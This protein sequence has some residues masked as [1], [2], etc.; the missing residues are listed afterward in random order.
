MIAFYSFVLVVSALALFYSSSKIVDILMKLEKKF[1]LREFIIGFFVMA[2]VSSLPNLFLAVTSALEKIPQLSFGDVIGGNVVD[3]T[4][5]AALAVLFNPSSIKTESRLAQKSAILCSLIAILPLFLVF[6]Q[7]LSRTDGIILIISFFIYALWTFSKRERFCKEY[8]ITKKERS[9]FAKF[10]IFVAIL[11]IIGLLFVLFLATQG[12][13]SSVREFSKAFNVSIPVIGLLIVGLG[14]CL[15]EMYLCVASARRKQGFMVLGDLMG[16][17]II[18]AT[19]V[20]GIAAVIHPIVITDFSPFVVARIFL[21]ISAF[22]FYFAVKS[23]R[24]ITKKEGLLLL[25][26]YVLFLISEAIILKS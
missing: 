5:V 26:L 6:D 12:I 20:L 13:I 2:F 15:P 8:R 17:V 10:N 24:E 19:L 22:F 9:F 1:G 11:K 3:L 21:V 18:C 7:K 4:L 14:N 16:S 23:G 25:S